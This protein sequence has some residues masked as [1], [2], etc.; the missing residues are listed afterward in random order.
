MTT[1]TQT[2]CKICD[3]NFTKTHN[4]QKFCSK[5]C[6]YKNKLLLHKE[7][8]QKLKQENPQKY[9][10]QHQNA[11]KKYYEK[12]K[13]KI[14]KWNKQYQKENLKLIN[15]KHREKYQNNPEYKRKQDIRQMHYYLKENLKKTSCEKCGST[16]NLRL[17]H[18]EYENSLDTEKLMTLCQKCHMEEHK[19]LNIPK[20]TN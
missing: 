2:L 4:S 10:S 15:E 17:H 7:L 9:L 18:K 5:E 6:A 8:Q 16:S 19:R 20:D 3:T 13:E 11:V 12:N 14:I 1:T